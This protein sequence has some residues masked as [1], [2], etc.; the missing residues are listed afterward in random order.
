[1]PSIDPAVAV[2]RLY[3]DPTFPPVKQKKKLFNDEKNTAIREERVATGSIG[4]PET[5]ILHQ[6][7]VEGYRGKVSHNR[8]SSFC[9]DNLRTSVRAQALADFITECTTRVPPVT[10]GPEAD[11]SKLTQ[12]DWILFVD[13]AR[14][15]QG[16][17]AGVIILGPQEETMEYTTRFSFPATNNEAEYEARYNLYNEL[18]EGVYIEVRDQPAYKGEV[19]KSVA[20]SNTRDW[21]NPII[22]YLTQ[23]VLPSDNHEAKKLCSASQPREQ[24]AKTVPRTWHASKLCKY[25]V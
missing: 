14:N 21:R 15:D 12:P 5:D 13:G 23:G 6:P 19:I 2:H 11:E 10:Q 7:C 17:G 1:M 16:I 22:K 4:H 24:N 3:T 9:P 8:Y 18:P 25:Y 20:D